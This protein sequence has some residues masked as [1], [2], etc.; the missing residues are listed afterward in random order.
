MLND[1][2][3]EARIEFYIAERLLLKRHPSVWTQT[4]QLA[5]QHHKSAL[6]ETHHAQHVLRP[7]GKLHVSRLGTVVDV[8]VHVS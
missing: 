1:P 5:L 2:T 6:A 7:V 4:A 8:A 3:P